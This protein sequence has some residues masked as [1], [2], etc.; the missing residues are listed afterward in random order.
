MLASAPWDDLLVVEARSADGVGLHLRV[1]PMAAPLD[2]VVL[3]LAQLVPG[4]AYV[5]TGN[6]AA[7]TVTAAADGTAVH[8]TTVGGPTTLE[9]QPA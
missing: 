2:V 9:V 4:A 5:V 7:T 1:E 8:R 3:G 6:G